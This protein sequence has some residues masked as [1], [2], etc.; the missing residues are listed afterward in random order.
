MWW[1]VY[2]SLLGTLAVWAPP[3][4]FD[5]LDP[6]FLVILGVVGT[7]RYGW[8]A[9][10]L[11]RAHLYRRVVFPRLRRRAEAAFAALTAPDDG[12]EG[13]S[14]R[15]PHVFLVITGYRYE[16]AVTAA[17]WRAAVL[18]AMRYGGPVTLVASLV[19]PADRRLVKDVFRVLAPPARVRLVLVELP[20]EGKR[21]AL[22]AALV[23]VARRAPRADDVVALMD[24][25]TLLTPRCLRRTVP[26]LSLAPRP[27]GV[28]TDERPLV[29]GSRL[30][31]AWFAL[32]FAQRHL[33]MCSLALSRRLLV[34]T[35]RFSLYPAHVATDPAFIDRIR[36]DEIE[37]WRLGRIRL[38]TGED[39]ST[40]LHLLEHGLD[41]LYVPDVTVL[42]AEALPE[43][44]F[45]AGATRLMRRWFGNM[46]RGSVRALALGPRRVGAFAWWCLVD[47]RLSMWTPVLGPLAAIAIAVAVDPL[48]LYAYLLWVLTTRL[49]LV[50]GLTTLRPGL[51][52]LAPLLLYF[53]QVYGALVKQWV[54]FRLDDQRWTRQPIARAGRSGAGARLSTWLAHGTAV[55]ALLVAVGFLTGLLELP[56][57]SAVVLP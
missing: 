57:A 50:L 15:L 21:E 53:N 28:T 20:P 26:L 35:G 9:V 37:H 49:V 16:A 46:L 55:L 29:R 52:G 30:V 45:L 10:H 41:M 44:R 25:D 27:G 18:E 56:P 43:R 32:R 48:F 7:W 22:A 3:R 2:L 38:L 47:Q 13:R 5:P 33:Y 51:D 39:K 12:D 11:I 24:G 40:W 42:T 6:R 17:C 54:L 1:V 36:R 19:E 4:L 31:R 8:G 23:A 14:A 34:M